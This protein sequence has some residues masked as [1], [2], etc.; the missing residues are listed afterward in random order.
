MSEGTSVRN[1][2]T[3]L[4]AAIFCG[5]LCGQTLQEAEA[6]H[7]AGRYFDSNDV[8]KQLQGRYAND[9]D[10]K[11]KW[12]MLFL[13]SEQPGDAAG[14]FQEALKLKPND[15][16]ALLGM[17]LA[18]AEGFDPR[19]ADWARK[20][21][22]ADPKLADAEAL[23]ARLA[24]EDNDNA[25]AADE[26]KKALAIDPNS[27]GGKSV[28]A[29]IDLL[30]DRKTE[31]DPKDARGYY[32]IGHFFVL[33]RRY[34]EGIGYLRKALELDPQLHRARS[35]LGV[36]L[37]RLGE[38]DEAARQLESLY[39][40]KYHSNPT[41]N[42][43]RLID[44]IRGFVTFKTDNTILK[45]DKGEANL[46]HPYFESEMKRAIATYEKK[47]RM[48]LE[49]PVQ[50]EV[51]PN[52]DDFAVRTLGMPGLGALG[53]TFG[54]D[55]AMDSP[56]GRK[57]GSFHWDSTLWHE[58]SHVF[59]LTATGHRVPRWFT[60]GMAVHEETAASPDWGDRITPDIIAAIKDKTLL[61]IAKLDR[62]FIHPDTPIQ[63]VVSY[64]QAG[65]IIDYIDDKWG[66]DTLLAMLHD[67]GAGID[68]VSVVRRNL[69]IEPE[70][71]DKRFLA[72]IDADTKTTVAHFDDWKKGMGEV[73]KAERAKDW[74]AVIK[75]GSAIRD[76][77][78]DY[79]EEHSIYEALAQAYTAKG[80]KAGAVAQ[81]EQYAKIGGRN[82]ETLKTLAR[83]LSAAG[84]KK[85]A[86][87]VLDKL[88]WI[89]PMDADAHQMLGDLWMEQGN[90]KGAIR[91]FGA[92]VARNPI[93]P[94]QAH[95]DLARALLADHQTDKANDECLNALEAAPGFRPAQKLLLE[96]S[97]SQ[98]PKK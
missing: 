76:W 59:T 73:I 19:A 58:M 94:A 74:D 63:I 46:L 67:F 50:V 69:K 16:R 75:Q 28:L 31:S 86:A 68:T 4:A 14:L 12:G 29:T 35:E 53:V 26:A 62:G 72:F 45:M 42:S 5:G 55:I 71:F 6:L 97:N 37:M 22:E 90:V 70:E 57:P 39:N 32:T 8:F 85:E 54:Y 40:Q 7:R 91:E 61:P 17:G 13:D 78:P 48:K 25:K 44:T 98:T 30:A 20:A 93:D 52:H 95:Y 56:S 41:I 10:F 36:N 96:L 1:L 27:V 87:A 77:Y 15:A 66:W 11:V 92:V 49:K 82:P 84:R 21:L 9:P 88:N 3:I 24:L 18:T 80:D 51:Y 83:E 38:I 60:E 65:R 79:V 34:E 47:Y 64:F 33:N 89:Y 2:G 81:L 43:L 23:L